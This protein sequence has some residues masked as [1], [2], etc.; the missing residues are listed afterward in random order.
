[1]S[2]SLFSVLAVAAASSVSADYGVGW[3]YT[4]T[5]FCG[6]N[7]A[8]NGVDFV[9]QGNTV[10][11]APFYKANTTSIYLYHDPDCL[12]NG[13]GNAFWLIDVHQPRKDVASNLDGD[14][15][16]DAIARIPSWDS[17]HP[18]VAGQWTMNCGR[19]FKSQSL[20]LVEFKSAAPMSSSSTMQARGNRTA[21]GQATHGAVVPNLIL[22]GV[23]H[24]YEGLNGLTFQYMGDAKDGSPLYKAQGVEEYLYF[25]T[26]CDASGN[27]TG[28]RW[29]L[30]DS[31][32]SS[33][34]LEDLDSDKACHYHARIGASSGLGGP[35]SSGSW[36][37]YCGSQGWITL[38][39]SFKQVRGTGNTTDMTLLS[40]AQSTAPLFVS[41]LLLALVQWRRLT[42]A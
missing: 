4:I 32:P 12:S 29:I 42:A 5:G 8:L 36:S 10:T 30:D 25:D 19:V 34:T 20:E 3:K 1:M 40:A 24:Q 31:R 23:C 22:T 39:L 28:G 26:D 13:E 41:V 21:E 18:P 14:G 27:S 6:E 33:S 17:S 9:Y 37:M 38:K 16:C 7:G 11:G 2:T 35:P 15:L